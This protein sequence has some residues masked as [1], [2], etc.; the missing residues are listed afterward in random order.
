MF[1]QA[2]EFKKKRVRARERNLAIYGK[3]SERLQIIWFYGS[4]T[5]LG[6]N[7][8]QPHNYDFDTLSTTHRKTNLLKLAVMSAPE[9]V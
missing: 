3:W 7:S 4:G 9:N 5:P 2:T 1:K 6:L 8:F